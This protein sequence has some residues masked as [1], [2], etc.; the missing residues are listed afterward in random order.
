M[1]LVR[2]LWFEKHSRVGHQFFKKPTKLALVILRFVGFILVFFIFFV[3]YVYFIA[4]IATCSMI[5][6]FSTF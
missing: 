5:A 1:N 3:P 6:P 2:Y 4:H